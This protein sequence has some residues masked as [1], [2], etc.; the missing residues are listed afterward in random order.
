[1]FCG[2]AAIPL[3]SSEWSARKR[4]LIFQPA[5]CSTAGTSVAKV[6]LVSCLGILIIVA[7]IVVGLHRMTAIQKKRT[8]VRAKRSRRCAA[9]RARWRTTMLCRLRDTMSWL[10]DHLSS[11]RGQQFFWIADARLVSVTTEIVH[12]NCSKLLGVCLDVEL[13][14]KKTKSG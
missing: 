11:A 12:L 14:V 13:C 6:P 7:S 5:L 9:A 10:E 1:M 8:C 2:C 3:L 4:L